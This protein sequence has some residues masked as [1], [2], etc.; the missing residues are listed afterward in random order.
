ME[1]ICDCGKL[2]FISYYITR[3][4]KGLPR[5]IPAKA[6][7]TKEVSDGDFNLLVASA[8]TLSSAR[9]TVATAP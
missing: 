8:S 2:F 1:G 9:F 7:M 3:A 5:V 4:S 6:G